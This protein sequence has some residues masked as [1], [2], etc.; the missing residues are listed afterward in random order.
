MPSSATDSEK[1][2][3]AV[4]LGTKGVDGVAEKLEETKIE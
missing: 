2:K 1:I 3:E 4:V